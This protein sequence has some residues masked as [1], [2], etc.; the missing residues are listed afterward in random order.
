[1][2]TVTT[3]YWP[4][5]TSAQ[6]NETTVGKVLRAA[7]A[8]A[9]GRL[10]MVGGVPDP[11]ARRRW[12]YAELLADAEQAA[13]ALTARFAPGERIAA[14]APNLPEWVILARGRLLVRCA[15]R[16]RWR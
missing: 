1:M 8:T 10:A 2:T 14:W 11:G 3:S 5:D 6:I 16:R 12:T 15:L 9:P 4:A 13:R 7:A